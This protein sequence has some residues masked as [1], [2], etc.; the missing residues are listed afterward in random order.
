MAMVAPTVAFGK[1]LPVLQGAA[2]STTSKVFIFNGAK[3]LGEAVVDANTGLWTFTPPAV[4]DGVFQLTAGAVCR[5][6]VWQRPLAPSFTRWTPAPG[7]AHGDGQPTATSDKRC[8]GQ[9]EKGASVE[10]FADGTS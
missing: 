3:Q 9:G 7:G 2:T 10:V 4:K 1:T 8:V 6:G 5:E